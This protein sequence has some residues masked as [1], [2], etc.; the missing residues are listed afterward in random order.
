MYVAI[1]YTFIYIFIIQIVNCFWEKKIKTTVIILKMK[2][3]E[4]SKFGWS[5]RYEDVRHRAAP[6][7]Q[8]W[9]EHTTRE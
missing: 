1:L 2:K 8:P 6:A 3:P 5:Y 7:P 9:E 4:P